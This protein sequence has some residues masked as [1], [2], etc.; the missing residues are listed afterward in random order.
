MEASR[1]LDSANVAESK[2]VPHIIKEEKQGCRKAD[3]HSGTL[4]LKA[5]LLTAPLHDQVVSRGANQKRAF[6]QY[7]Y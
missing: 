6:S 1:V 2:N 3:S 5:A 7:L 4:Y